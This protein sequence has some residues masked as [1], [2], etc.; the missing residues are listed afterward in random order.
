[1]KK[2]KY[3]VIIFTM[4]FLIILQ[5]LFSVS[6]A[7][8][9]MTV[10]S[11]HL[12]SEIQMVNHPTTDNPAIVYFDSSTH[13]F[14]Y[15]ILNN[16][17]WDIT[18]VKSFTN[19]SISDWDACLDF[20]FET[21]YPCVTYFD[22][23]W[24]L[25]YACSLG[26]SQ[27]YDE[28]VDYDVYSG[29]TSFAFDHNGTPWIAYQD[30]DKIAYQVRIKI[31]KKSGINWNLSVFE[32]DAAN[33]NLAINPATG[34]P[35]VAYFKISSYA[36]LKVKLMYAYFNGSVWVK[37]VVDKQS[38]ISPA[39]PSLAFN[40]GSNHPAIAYSAEIIEDDG[41]LRYS[42]WNGS[43]WIKETVDD[44]GN[45][46]GQIGLAFNP[47]S[48]HPA[49]VYCIEDGSTWPDPHDTPLMYAHYDGSQWTKEVV[50]T[51]Q[52]TNLIY[53]KSL[54][55][56]RQGDARIAYDV[57]GDAKIRQQT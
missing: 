4:A 12:G 45:I 9:I 11:V 1:M 35:S 38:Y 15:S 36:P 55:F 32:E 26:G 21:G 13:E 43:S 54:V 23:N 47:R 46:W 5:G 44:T 20:D 19:Y 53:E 50:D 39:L 3:F 37:E 2:R 56:G 22:G 16:N 17:L 14:K 25:F 24:N 52:Y 48:G 33:V 31:A 51:V 7:W 8:E 27:W 57:G 42:Y 10:D 49:I 30:Y 18:V 41:N 34:Y 28:P 29:V 40:P 6:V